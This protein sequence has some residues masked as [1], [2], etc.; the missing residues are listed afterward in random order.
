M[1][2]LVSHGHARGMSICEELVCTLIQAIQVAGI[3]TA[4]PI[5]FVQAAFGF[6]AGFNELHWYKD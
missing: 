6:S 1:P 4:V 5:G 3:E 2:K